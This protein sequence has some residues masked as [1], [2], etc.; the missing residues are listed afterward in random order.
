VYFLLGKKLWI[1]YQSN[2]R[3]L[4]KGKEAVRKMKQNKNK[5]QKGI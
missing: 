1:T 2:Q 5:N 3:R 4:D